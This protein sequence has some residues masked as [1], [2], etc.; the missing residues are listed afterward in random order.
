VSKIIIPAR[1]CGPPNSGNGGYTCGLVAHALGGGAEVTLRKPIPIEQ[2]MEIHVHGT[3]AELKRGDELIAE[4]KSARWTCTRHHRASLGEAEAAAAKSPAFKNHPFP[5]CFVCGPDRAPGDGLRIFPGEIQSSNGAHVFAAPWVPAGEFAD[6]NGNIR[7]H[8][9]WAALDCPT[10]FAAGFPYE[11]KLLTGRLGV[12]IDAP[13]RAGERCVLVSWRTAVEGRKHQAEA[14]LL[15]EDSS[16][17]AH[18][19]ATWIKLN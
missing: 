12:N 5:T 14:V 6:E 10:G 17:R 15:G 9:L 1:F 19:R 13:V 2:A 8:F 16:V 18:A 3:A 4:G 11:G 7:E